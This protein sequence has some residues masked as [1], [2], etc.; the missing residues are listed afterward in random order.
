MLTCRVMRA[1]SDVC[2]QSNTGMPRYVSEPSNARVQSIAR[3]QSIARVLSDAPVLSDAFM[4]SNA[5]VTS[6]ARQ[7][8]PPIQEKCL[9]GVGDTGSVHFSQLGGHRSSHAHC[10]T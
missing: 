8:M 5:R 7:D 10:S 3:M 2:M 6:D 1:P 9:T 4:S